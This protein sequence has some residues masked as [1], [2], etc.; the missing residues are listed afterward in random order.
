MSL[1]WFGIVG[2]HELSGSIVLNSPVFLISAIAF[3]LIT[4]ANYNN[5]IIKFS[6]SIV[7]LFGII[8]VEIYY[9]FMWFI[10]TNQDKINLQFSLKTAFDGFY[11]GLFS[12]IAMF[13]FYIIY[14][15]IIYKKI[16]S[17]QSKTI[18]LNTPVNIKQKIIFSIAFILTLLPLALN[19]TEGY[20]TYRGSILFNFKGA[21]A[22]IIVFLVITWA[23]CKNYIFKTIISV[24]SLLG[25]V[26]IEV[27][28][29][30]SIIFDKYH[31]Y[32]ILPGL[33][34]AILCSIAMLVFYIIYSTVIYRT[35]KNKQ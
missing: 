10:Q 11:I 31:P 6:I 13:I 19:W 29:I 32:T 21:Y 27:L 7:C 30:I 35:Q 26:G 23:D 25:L 28:F 3:F 34:L 16:T 18:G 22:F 5:Y 8:C 4:W 12:S 15:I 20:F 9:F 2:V 1:N 14:S 17:D 24:L 33:Y